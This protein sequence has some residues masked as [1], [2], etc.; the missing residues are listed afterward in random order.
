MSAIST[1]SKPPTLLVITCLCLVSLSAPIYVYSDTQNTIRT[2]SATG[3]SS[4]PPESRDI[5]LAYQQSRDSFPKAHMPA[6]QK[7]TLNDDPRDL[8]VFFMIGIAINIIM[9][10][11][12]AWWFSREWRKSGK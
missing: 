5:S 7:T 4:N 1:L 6:K 8:E 2:R 3:S 11:V 10:V 12:F 9:A